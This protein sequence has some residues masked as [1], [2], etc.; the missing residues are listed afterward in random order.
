MA[1]T[2]K[3]VN[4]DGL[5]HYDNKIKEHVAE[6][7]GELEVR[8]A[9]TE[10]VVALTNDVRQLQIDVSNEAIKVQNMDRR[11]ADA[12]TGLAE[13]TSKTND[14]SVTLARVETAQEGMAKRYELN[15]Y[16]KTEQ[17]DKKIADAVKATTV[18]F[19]EYYKKGD[20]DASIAILRNEVVENTTNVDNIH[21]TVDTIQEA[22]MRDHELLEGLLTGIQNKSDEDHKHNLTD[23]I[24]FVAPDLDN[25][26]T[27][28]QLEGL[29]TQDF[30]R[31]AI[32][33]A[34]IGDVDLTNFYTKAE[35]DSKIASKVDNSQY[36]ADKTKFVTVEQLD[37]YVSDEELDEVS[38]S[39][40]ELAA[41]VDQQR[42]ALQDLQQD[43][44]AQEEALRD[45][46][47]ALASKL[48]AA[49]YEDDKATFALKSDLESLAS[50]QWVEEQGFLKDQ[51]LSDYAKKSEIPSI[52]NKADKATTL[53]GYGITDAYTRTQIDNKLTE[54]STGGNINL[55][56]YVSE[57]EWNS[58]IVDY[59]KTS[60][61]F[62]KD[63]NDLINT[64][65]IP[66]IEGLATIDELNDV[67]AKIPT[68]YLVASD[69]A[70]KADR[71]ELT[72]LAT[73]A[74]V[75]AVEAKVDAI[76]IPEV[77]T[78]VSK[79]ENDAGYIT[80]S[81]VP[82]TDLS[83]YYTIDQIDELHTPIVL[84]TGNNATAIEF[85]ETLQTA[86]DK[87][88]PV[89][90]MDDA[91]IC[92]LAGFDATTNV[93]YFHNPLANMYVTVTVTDGELIVDK[94]ATVPGEYI[95]EDELDAR[96]FIT[97]TDIESHIPA[98][99]ITEDELSGKGY[100]T[101]GYVAEAIAGLKQPEVDLSNY[102]T[103][104]ETYT[105]DEIDS[106]IANIE[107][108]SVPT[109]V[110]DLENDLKYTTLDAVA[111]VGYIT[112]VPDKYITAEELAAEG[113]LKEHQSL[114]GYAKLTDIPTNYLTE[115]PSEYITETEL[116]D[117]GYLTEQSLEGYATEQYVEDAIAEIPDVDTSMFITNDTLASALLTKA[118]DVVFTEDMRVGTALGQFVENESLKDLTLAQILTK[119]LNLTAYVPPT[120][121]IE[122]P[123][124]TPDVVVEIVAAK[125]P[126]Y[127]LDKDGS[128]VEVTN[129]E[130]YYRELTPQEATVDNQEDSFFYQIV[131]DTTGQ[132]VES[133]YQIVTIEHEID[134][135]T[136]LIPNSITK[137]HVEEYSAL[138]GDWSEPTWKLV[139]NPNYSV[140]GH[141][142]YTVP[143]EYEVLSGI[144][145][146][147]VIE[148]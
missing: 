40:T 24:D 100:A 148:D 78:K 53:E 135:L 69:I 123:E 23:I 102:Y 17:V 71:S 88:T 51:D 142:A 109:K 97:S 146:R 127:T 110:S 122:L 113:F 30:V 7:V 104:D 44:S 36:Q 125:E 145:V 66:S 87:G 43:L 94:A 112:K 99:Y 20:V 21:K 55:D 114:E 132:V 147:I 9:S 10:D 68:D 111:Q 90:W 118:N 34:D 16:A 106:A 58:R 15:D 27:K 89:Y 3:Y 124:G 1:D 38:N 138:A 91:H 5:V 137:F 96:G 67:E 105:R 128:I 98:K 61:L 75:T 63:Y 2:T 85:L 136:V 143:E 129:Q 134:Y 54:L 130:D 80:V 47:T 133:G 121:D 56:G 22:T 65:T 60:D 95:T 35:T 29:A 115:V 52:E 79:F 8:T 50:I 86:M 120:P 82:K 49:D 119:L 70:N 92:T 45:L 116:S 12:E 46:D 28:D 32:A 76:V 39:V 141:T 107:H 126:A 48:D 144:A 131:D 33:E 41:T 14:I 139:E 72:E 140:E 81:E 62:S 13:V 6:V 31:A 26:A 37:A 42:L 73:K 59:A 25:Y 93:A 117:K 19:S 74:E 4:W 84:N 18:D 83:N 57:D 11:L 103:K 101:E 64:P 108:P 77:P